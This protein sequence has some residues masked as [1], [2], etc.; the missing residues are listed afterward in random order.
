MKNNLK[1]LIPSLLLLLWTVDGWSQDINGY[2]SSIFK[3]QKTGCDDLTRSNSTGGSFPIL[4]DAFN[5]LSA[6][7]PTFTTPVGVEAFYDREKF[8]FSMIKGFEGV[9][10]G[11]SVTKS[12]NT[13]YSPFNNM[14]TYLLQNHLSTIAAEAKPNTNI[15]FAFNLFGA[16]GAFLQSNV[17]VSTKYIAADN[18]WAKEAALSLQIPYLN[19]GYSLTSKKAS[20]TIHTITAGLRLWRL[21]ADYVHFRDVLGSTTIT[22]NIVSANLSFSY[23]HFTYAIRKQD[24]PYVDQIITLANQYAP[25]FPIDYQSVHHLFGG[26]FKLGSKLSVGAYMNYILNKGGSMVVQYFF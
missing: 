4:Y 6:A 14:N 1:Q 15:G 5:V 22:T 16:K 25:G 8:N 9:G 10:A 23:F 19:L 12:A 13:F 17:G 2:C 21:V 7:L 24:N 3:G 20:E 26:T 11:A 18:F